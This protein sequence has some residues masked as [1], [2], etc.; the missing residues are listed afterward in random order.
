MHV[1]PEFS[2]HDDVESSENG[3]PSRNRFAQVTIAVVALL[4]VTGMVFPLL[5]SAV[6][7]L[8]S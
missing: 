7:G 3:R 8:L 4:A 1:K 2:S 5:A 6:S